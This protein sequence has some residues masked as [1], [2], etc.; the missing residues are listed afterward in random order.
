MPSRDELRE[1]CRKYYIKNREKIKAIRREYYEAHTE[2][3]EAQRK[4]YYAIVKKELEKQ[5]CLICGAAK[6]E[7]HHFDYNKPVDVMWLCQTHHRAWHRVFIAEG[8]SMSKTTKAQAA[9]ERRDR[10]RDY[11]NRFEDYQSNCIAYDAYQQCLADVLE[12]IN[13]SPDRFLITPLRQGGGVQAMIIDDLKKF[14]G[15][16]DV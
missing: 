3:Y 1:R 7:A 6:S 13:N 11:A 14:A 9:L 4:V 2:K 16:E 15:G 5:D 10:A 12:F 8:K